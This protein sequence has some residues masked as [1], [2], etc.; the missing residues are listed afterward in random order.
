MQSGQLG[1]NNAV[2]HSMGSTNVGFLWGLSRSL[3]GQIIALS[4]RQTVFEFALP[5]L[6]NLAAFLHGYTSLR[7][8][9]LWGSG[10][11]STF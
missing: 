3:F 2:L 5:P 7:Q 1:M 10:C 6:T 8:S 11:P 4:I 9:S